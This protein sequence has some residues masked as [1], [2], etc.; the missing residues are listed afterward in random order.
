MTLEGKSLLLGLL[1]SVGIFAVRSGIELRYFTDREKQSAVFFAFI[2]T[3]GLL[4]GISEICLAYADKTFLLQ[5]IQT[6]LKSGMLIHFLMAACML[7]AGLVCLGADIGETKNNQLKLIVPCP[8]CIIFIILSTESFMVYLPDIAA[9]AIFS[10]YLS[11]IVIAFMSA[12]LSEYDV[13]GINQ[14]T[15]GTAMLIL[16]AY[17][18]LSVLILPQFSDLAEIAGLASHSHDD[19]KSSM[20]AMLIFIAIHGILFASGY[21]KMSERV[22][23]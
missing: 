11:F 2:C 17:F 20:T 6:I 5:T 14:D 1:L 12:W 23:R 19:G 18:M 7:A 13:I 21:L 16:S 22:R 15:V 3:Y 4:F 9:W 8:V 10:L